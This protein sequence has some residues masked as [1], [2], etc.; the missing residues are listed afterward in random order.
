[1]R[2]RTPGGAGEAPDHHAML[3]YDDDYEFVDRVASY[4]GSVG[5]DGEAG[6]AILTE[7][8]WAMVE[9]SLG[10]GSRVVFVQR[11]EV[12]KRPEM[13]VAYYDDHVRRLERE[14]ATMVR[15]IAD[16]PAWKR[17]EQRL[18]WLR[19]EAVLN[20]AFTHH[21]VSLLC[22]YD[23]RVQPP[24]VVDAAWRTHPR[25]LA[26]AWEDNPL[27]EDPAEIIDAITPSPDPL[28]GLRTLA[29]DVDRE[30]ATERLR[31]ELKALQVPRTRA[32]NL[33]RAAAE[34]LDNANAH[35]G[36]PRS[37]RLGSVGGQIVW[38]LTDGGGGFDDPLAGY[39]PDPGRAKDTGLWAVR[40]LTKRLEF[41][42]SSD[43]FTVRVWV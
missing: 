6:L 3:L 7:R 38:E 34:V 8:R 21:P 37:Q 20:R 30:A 32:K 1:M 18:A 43:G 40:Q 35:G 2:P 13:T 12:Y 19:Y 28:D 16:L 41:L 11:S 42:K 39:V 25:V 5:E 31:R 10:A 14:G 33:L 27:Y 24:G 29:V 26:D 4:L 36:G 23:A 22:A 15:V 17:P 9:R